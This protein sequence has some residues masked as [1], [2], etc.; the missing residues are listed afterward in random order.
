MGLSMLVYPLAFLNQI[1]MSYYF[2]TS[3][4]VDAYW[5]LLALVNLLIFYVI[6]AKDALV[7]EFFNRRR[8]DADAGNIYFSQTANF[9]LILI[10]LSCVSLALFPRF[11]TELVVDDRQP[12]LIEHVVRLVPYVVPLVFLTS[13]TE[14]LNGILVSYNKVLF[15]HIGRVIGASTS[16]VFLLLLAPYIHIMALVLA[17]VVSPLILLIIQLVEL[18]KVGLGYHLFQ[19][20]RTDPTFRRMIGALLLSYGF[21]QIHVI[22]ERSVFSFF[23]TGVIASYQYASSISHIPQSIIIVALATVLWP[24]FMELAQEKDYRRLYQLTF[25][26]TQKLLLVLCLI[27]LLIWFF[28]SE[29][30][31]I[32]FFRGAFDKQSLQMTS[33]SLKALVLCITPIGATQIISR[34]LITLQQ[35][36]AMLAGGLTIVFTA[37]AILLFG[38]FT[39]ELRISLYH[40]ATGTAVGYLVLL[41]AFLRFLSRRCGIRPDY[42]KA[43]LWLLKLV[44]IVSGLGLLYPNEMISLPFEVLHPKFWVL[45]EL[46]IHSSVITVLYIIL[47]LLLR[48]Y[49]VGELVT[50]IKSVNSKASAVKASAT[51]DSPRY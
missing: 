48:L 34:A 11:F 7:P 29:I 31:H 15:Q 14:L 22:L 51:N 28:S 37:G 21:S 33:I 1:L 49:S 2:G 36:K 30:I 40:L 9:L 42:P 26:T 24:R 6:A 19:R 16:V 46:I 8:I 20:P 45:V 23:G 4:A 47:G 27:S 13:A 43:S 5:I 10:I 44:L 32:L 12:Q 41:V 35:A 3:A 50:M 25:E 17:V 18:R 39:N 38:R